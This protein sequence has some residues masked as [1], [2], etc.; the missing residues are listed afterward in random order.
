MGIKRFQCRFNLHHIGFG[1]RVD[2][3]FYPIEITLMLPFFSVFVGIG[4]E[5][6]W[7]GLERAKE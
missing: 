7:K 6:D 1:L 4:K 5:K 3:F 2:W